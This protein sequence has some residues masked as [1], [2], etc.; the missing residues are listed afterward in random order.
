MPFKIILPSLAIPEFKF[1]LLESNQIL[2]QESL[3]FLSEISHP[4]IFVT[5]PVF[6][7][8]LEPSTLIDLHSNINVD[9]L[10]DSSEST[11]L[12]YLKNI[13]LNNADQDLFIVNPVLNNRFNNRGGSWNQALYDRFG[14]MLTTSMQTFYG[15]P[16]YNNYQSY[17]IPLSNEH[18]HIKVSTFQLL[19][20]VI[21][22]Y[23]RFDCLDYFYFP[24][25]YEY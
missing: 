5:I 17:L 18:K 8:V 24:S 4:D 13:T 12:Q 21:N 23:V 3:R 9:V 1:P 20:N 6:N 22:N 16:P 15:N 14:N 19:S 11:V 25:K 2:K 7:T 10:S